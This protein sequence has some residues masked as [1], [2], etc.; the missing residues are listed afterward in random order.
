MTQTIYDIDGFNQRKSAK[1]SVLFFEEQSQS[2]T[3]YIKIE[4]L[5]FTSE[6]SNLLQLAA[7][8]FSQN[9]SFKTK[10]YF[11]SLQKNKS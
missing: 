5:N 9:S 8:G 2:K 1:I 10:S 11:L 6:T 7:C 3:N 4:I